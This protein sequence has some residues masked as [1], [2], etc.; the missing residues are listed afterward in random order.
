MLDAV[1]RILNRYTMYKIVLY[2]FRVFFTAAI[3]LAA[4]HVIGV[5][6]VGI[7]LS[8]TVLVA[9]CF[10]T[11]ELFSRLLRVPS[12]SQSWLITALILVCVLPPA[13]GVSRSLY[14]ALAGVIAMA[15]KY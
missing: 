15:S 7:G 14:I 4:T 5:S 10:L 12:N 8:I 13:H 9:S 3:V 6:A 2:S 1:D 11:N